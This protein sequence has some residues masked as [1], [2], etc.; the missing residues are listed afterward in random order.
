MTAQAS[1][2]SPAA[3]QPAEGKAPEKAGRTQDS[4][5]QNSGASASAP[6]EGRDDA[7]GRGPGSPRG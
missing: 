7:P 5:A 2:K 3:N 6:A 1:G 4:H